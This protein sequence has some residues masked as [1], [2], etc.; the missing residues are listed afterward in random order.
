[1][2]IHRAANVT[3]CAVVFRQQYSWLSTISPD[4]YISWKDTLCHVTCHIYLYGMTPKMY[5]I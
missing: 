2:D 3:V 1:M 4:V 5:T